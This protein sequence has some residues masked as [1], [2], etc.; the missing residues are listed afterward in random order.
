MHKTHTDIVQS[1]Q[2]I[3]DLCHAAEDA[4][5]TAFARTAELAQQLALFA[6]DTGMS[7]HEARPSLHRVQAALSAQTDGLSK[8]GETHMRAEKDLGALA[9][10]TKMDIPITCPEFAVAEDANVTELKVA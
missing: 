5:L 7:A 2:A 8:I 4:A 3:G 1:A 10:Q 9:E 6:R